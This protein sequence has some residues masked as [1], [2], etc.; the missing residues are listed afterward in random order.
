MS[1]TLSI[2][3][4]VKDDPTGL[5]RTQHSLHDCYTHDIHEIEWIIVDG[6]TDTDVVPRIVGNGSIHGNVHWVPPEGVYEAMNVGLHRTTGDYVYFLNAGDRLRDP[7]ALST[8]LHATKNDQP[9]WFYGQ[10]AF[11][12]PDGKEVVPPP[13]DY[14]AERATHFSRGRFPPHQ[15]TI[16][17]RE[18]LL[19]IGGFDPS[20]RIT[21][22]YTAMLQLSLIA[23]PIEIP[24]VIG[25]FTTGGLSEARWLLAINEFHRARLEICRPQ[26][27][28]L[29]IEFLN[30]AGQASKAI[31]SRVSKRLRTGL[32]GSE[33]R[34]RQ[35]K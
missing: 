6:S 3:T 28:Q 32:R 17:R 10:V 31:T 2:V 5:T 27:R 16:V 13:F 1:P 34:S 19:S 25:E 9:T 30:T 18:A 4:V 26:G 24:E 35:M 8:I 11:V 20:Y 7:Q 21:A 23:D 14:Q 33:A 15:G 29:V 22:D 12:S